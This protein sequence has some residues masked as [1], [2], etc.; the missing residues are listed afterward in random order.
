MFAM[1]RGACPPGSST[2]EADRATTHLVHGRRPA[3][4]MTRELT[5]QTNPRN[6]G[7]LTGIGPT[8]TKARRS[9]RASSR[10]IPSHGGTSASPSARVGAHFLQ[11]DGGDFTCDG[12]G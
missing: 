2:F 9:I 4:M 5:A 10:H 11:G 6:R 1:P 8:A 3:G 7:K 12:F